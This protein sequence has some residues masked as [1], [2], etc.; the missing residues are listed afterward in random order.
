LLTVSID[1]RDTPEDARHKRAE[2]LGLIHEG[3]TVIP[4]EGG[5]HSAEAESASRKVGDHGGEAGVASRK[6]GD[7]GGEVS[8]GGE[9]GA[10]SAR[11][12]GEPAWEPW[13]F[14]VGAE[15]E[16]QVLA[17]TLG[18]GYRYDAVTDQYSHPA[19]I[20]VLTPAGEI[21]SYIY[22][23]NPEPAELDA[24]LSSAAAGRTRATLERI[25][26][27]CFHYIPALRQYAGL[28][29]GMLWACGIF[30]IIGLGAVLGRLWFREL[31]GE[32]S[33]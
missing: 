27:R 32:L 30:T 6:A 25:L 22:G 7:G 10:S 26:L 2:L 28:I 12:D 20:F 18:F 8:S 13:T 17:G 11:I 3:P 23:I 31:R 19:V 4:M 5:D 16:I 9:A 24:A 1:P 33:R 14:L 21:S 15:P 29:R